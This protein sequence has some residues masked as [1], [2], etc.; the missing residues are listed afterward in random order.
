MKCFAIIGLSCL[1]PIY[2]Q[3]AIRSSNHSRVGQETGLNKSVNVS[4]NILLDTTLNCEIEKFKFNKENA[5]KVKICLD[6]HDYSY[7]KIIL[8]SDSI[9]SDK[10]TR[11]NFD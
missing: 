8:S 9:I 6:Q 10:M 11:I 7:D 4:V 1:V 5:I 3:Y 2:A